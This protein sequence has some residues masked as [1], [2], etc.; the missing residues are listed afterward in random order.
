[1][2]VTAASGRCITSLRLTRFAARLHSTVP[3][4]TAVSRAPQGGGESTRSD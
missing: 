1:M 2:N 4:W 3:I